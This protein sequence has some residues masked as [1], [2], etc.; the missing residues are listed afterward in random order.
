MRVALAVA[1]A[2]LAACSTAAPEPAR[3]P[4]PRTAMA[5]CPRTISGHDGVHNTGNGLAQRLVPGTPG[6]ARICRYSPLLGVQ[7]PQ[8]L[9]G[10]LYAERALTAADA[11]A[12][13]TALNAIPA[14]TSAEHSCPN[15]S[16][17]VDLLAFR[18]PGRADVEIWSSSSGCWSFSN[19]RRRTGAWSP[20]L[21]HYQALLQSW[22]PAQSD[23]YAGPGGARGTVQGRLLA[24]FGMQRAH[25]ISGK[26]YI[27]G[28]DAQPIGVGA[29]GVFAV[30]LA[31]GTYTL[32]GRSSEYNAG[33]GIC[34]TERPVTVVDGQTVQADVICIGK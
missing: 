3:S 26:I 11:S 28:R 17:R 18:L 4:A 27:S 33:R 12:L 10:V 29:D 14:D 22:A 19:G 16:G 25:P 21:E 34:R 2:A 24:E 30:T 8:V 5:A 23:V 1:T 15:D 6:A 13:A 20:A 7:A 32:T 31:P 9:H